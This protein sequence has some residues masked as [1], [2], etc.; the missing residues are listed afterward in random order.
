MAKDKQRLLVIDCK[1]GDKGFKHSVLQ[2]NIKDGQ[3][4]VDCVDQ[5]YISQ[6]LDPSWIQEYTKDPVQFIKDVT[7]PP[8]PDLM[9]EM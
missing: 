1:G 6:V 8:F 3:K 2:V 5:T 4:T 9:D 7:A